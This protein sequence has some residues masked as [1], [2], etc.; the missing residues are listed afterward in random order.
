MMPLWKRGRKG[1]SMNRVFSRVAITLGALLMAL[2][3][4]GIGFTPTLAAS[5]ATSATDPLVVIAQDTTA[6]SSCTMETTM[7]DSTVQS[8]CP[9]GTVIGTMK[10]TLSQALAE[11]EDYVLLP[12]GTID[13]TTAAQLDKQIHD[14]MVAKSTAIQH[15]STPMT[16]FIS[17]TPSTQCAYQ[18]N[19]T[20]SANWTPTFNGSIHLY[21]SVT[22]LRET[23]CYLYI[24]HSQMRGVNV[25]S[26]VYWW[27]DAYAADTWGRGCHSIGN[28]TDQQNT[29]T[30]EVA[31]YYYEPTVRDG[32]W[33]T[34]LDNTSWVNLGLL[35]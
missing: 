13:A 19:I 25:P 33:C 21:S 29:N 2:T 26:P 35:L 11:H 5:P 23:S 32:S 20:K 12:S 3:T 14:L 10:V 24:Y 27:Q 15:P 16:P 4:A 17:Q 9:A 6:S 8:A 18:D 30:L 7:N 22:Y 34:P 28:S 1:F 31:G